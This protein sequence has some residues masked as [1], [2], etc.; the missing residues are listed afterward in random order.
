MLTAS[1]RKTRQFDA[2]RRALGCDYRS[3]GFENANPFCERAVPYVNRLSAGDRW[4]CLLGNRPIFDVQQRG[5]VCE[6][7]QPKPA[8][9][10]VAVDL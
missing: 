8:R 4:P 6:R 1:P 9:E 10:R 5:A 7:A 2:P 3:S